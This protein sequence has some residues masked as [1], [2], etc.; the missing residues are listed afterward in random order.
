MVESED[1]EDNYERLKLILGLKSSRLN[2]SSKQAH[3][4]ILRNV[5]VPG[6]KLPV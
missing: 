5:V 1:F 4:S 3:V 6:K 2:C